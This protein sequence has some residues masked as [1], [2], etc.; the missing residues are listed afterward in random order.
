MR[1]KKKEQKT[2]LQKNLT[3]GAGEGTT[4]VSNLNMVKFTLKEAEV[5]DSNITKVEHYPAR[6]AGKQEYKDLYQLQEV[7]RSGKGY[8]CQGENGNFHL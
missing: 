5:D 3:E 2:S 8:S 7:S 1:H 4:K 6:V